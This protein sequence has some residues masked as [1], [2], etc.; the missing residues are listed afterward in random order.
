MLNGWMW[1]TFM[2]TWRSRSCMPRISCLALLYL[3]SSELNS[4]CIKIE[5][6]GTR[7][8]EIHENS[9]LL[10]DMVRSWRGQEENS[11]RGQV[12]MVDVS[13]F[14]VGNP[15]GFLRILLCFKKNPRR[16]LKDCW[17]SYLSLSECDLVG[18]D[19][20]LDVFVRENISV[21]HFRVPAIGLQFRQLKTT[22]KSISKTMDAR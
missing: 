2:M 22:Q 21:V 8:R 15:R 17:K 12:S 11:L 7:W 6:K 19:F 4:F 3:S 13:T 1:R 20:V 5:T 10:F 16:L 9:K 18:V 14:N